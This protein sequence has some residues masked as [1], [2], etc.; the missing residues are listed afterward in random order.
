[1]FGIRRD[2]RSL[3]SKICTS[4]RQIH[5]TSTFPF[6]IW[7]DNK[8]VD[9]ISPKQEKKL[10]VKANEKNVM[11]NRFRPP[12]MANHE[13][14]D[15]SYNGIHYDRITKE[16]KTEFQNCIHGLMDMLEISYESIDDLLSESERIKM[17]ETINKIENEIQTS[18]ERTDTRHIL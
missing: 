6:K 1:M 9:Y 8:L 14:S 18:K 12:K 2:F 5:V 3:I 13:T 15:S 7:Q 16:S 17:N 11:T 4:T 10:E